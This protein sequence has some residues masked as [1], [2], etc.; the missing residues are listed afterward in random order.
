VSAPTMTR[1]EC[2]AERTRTAEVARKLLALLPDTATTREGVELMATEAEAA[3][4]HLTPRAAIPNTRTKVGDWVRVCW[5]ASGDT[6]AH[7][8]RCWVQ[9]M[10]VC[11]FRG[12]Y[13]G[14]STWHRSWVRV[15]GGAV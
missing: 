2:I 14:L 10:H 5:T 4:H 9:V 12:V 7:I 3:V 15:K 8:S 13:L 1:A 11:P 6:P